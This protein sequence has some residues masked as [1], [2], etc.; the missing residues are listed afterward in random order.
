VTVTK[1]IAVT[2]AVLTI[3]SASVTEAAQQRP[4]RATDQ[5]VKDLVSRIEIHTETF[6][7]NFDRAVDRTRINGEDQ[8][9]SVKNF[10]QAIDQL[11]DRVKNRRSGTADVEDV[12]R[13]AS[14]IDSI[15]TAHYQDNVVGRPWQTLRRDLDELARAYGVAWRWASFEQSSSRVSDHEVGQLLGQ[16]EQNPDQVRHSL[17]QA[18]A[19]F[20]V[21]GGTRVMVTLDTAISTATARH[22]DRV[23]MTTR[24]PSRYQGAVIE[25]VVSRVNAV[26]RQSG[27]ADLSLVF[28]NIR[29]RDGRTYQ[30]SGVIENVRTPGGEAIRVDNEGAVEKENNQTGRGVEG[31]VIGAVIGAGGAGTVIL[32]GRDQLDLPRGTELTIISSTPRG[33]AEATGAQ[34]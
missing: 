27:R 29:L 11:S 25:A 16:R 17:D 2:V 18:G 33:P 10:E 4:Y 21:P 13:R 28:E 5:Q 26:G 15:V 12:L 19:N 9:Q 32:E 20:L 23:T 31:A 7:A 6:S 34:R 3:L 30:F 8:I 1:R 14:L 22:G 24:N